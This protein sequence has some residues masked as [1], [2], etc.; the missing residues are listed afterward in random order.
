MSACVVLAI[1]GSKQAEEAF[2][3]YL[4]Q[5]HKDGNKVILT[6]AMELPTMPS[7]DEYEKQTSAGKKKKAE[8]EEKYG[9]RLTELG[10]EWAFTAE[11]EKPGE[12][13]VETATKNK[14]DFIVIG[15]RGLGKVRRTIMGSVSDFVVHHANCPV[16]VCR[17]K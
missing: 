17:H 6:H 5:L 1:D 16:L 2:E 4:A 10:I 13:V 8:L 7:R 14:A 15:T 12:F 3:W 9:G 11:I